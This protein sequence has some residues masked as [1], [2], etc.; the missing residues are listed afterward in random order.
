MDYKVRFKGI[1]IFRNGAWEPVDDAAK[2]QLNNTVNTASIPEQV[3]AIQ[4]PDI[5]SKDT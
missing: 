5:S 1:E 4:L 2:F 3:A